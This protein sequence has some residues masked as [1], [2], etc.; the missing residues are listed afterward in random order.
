MT[1][2][3]EI[4]E[5]AK[6]IEGVEVWECSDRFMI[7]VNDFLG[8]T[9]DWDEE[10]NDDLDEEKLDQLL[11]MLPNTYKGWEGNRRY[12]VEGICISLDYTSADI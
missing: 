6:T 12:E 11:D 1:K 7:E 2:A 4:I 5:F 9:A 8:F 3:M 10:Y